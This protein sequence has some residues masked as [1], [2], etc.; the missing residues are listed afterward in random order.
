MS[1]AEMRF[2]T[3]R[4]PRASPTTLIQGHNRKSLVWPGQIA[5]GR[6]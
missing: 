5:A 2:A 6:L 4:A 1:H 3:V